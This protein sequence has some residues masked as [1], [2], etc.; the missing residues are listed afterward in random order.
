ML[1]LRRFYPFALRCCQCRTVSSDPLLSQ[2]SNCTHE[3]EVFDLVGKNKT[4][5]SE[6]H[7]GSAIDI[8]WQFQEKK[9][10][11]PRNSDYVKNHSHFIM[12]NNLAENK[13]SYMDNEALIHMLYNILRSAVLGVE[14]HDSLVREL[15]VE[16]WR[17]LDGLSLAALSKFALCLHKQKLVKSPLMGQ[18]A[19]IVNKNLDSMQDTRVLPVLM[20]SISSVISKNL[21]NRLMQK[22]EGALENI[23]LVSSDHAMHFVQFLRNIKLQHHPL[24]DKCNR[25]FLRDAKQLDV[26]ELSTILQLYHSL[27]F[28]N[29]AFRLVAKQRLMA[30]MDECNNPLSFTQLFAALAPMAG[31]AVREQL[32]ETALLIADEFDHLQTLAVVEALKEMKYRNSQLI[33]KITD[34]LHKHLDMYRST[35]LARL[36][37][38]IVFLQVHDPDFYSKLQKWLIRRLQESVT[39]TDI[40]IL[41]HLVSIL[42][43]SHMDEAIAARIDGI[44][45][46]CN[47][48]YLNFFATA[49]TKWVRHNQSNQRRG[50][51]LHG[52][53]LQ[54]IK[55]HAFQRLQQANDLDHLLEELKFLAG[56]WFEEILLEQTMV[57]LQRL[58]DQIAWKNM[59]LYSSFIV[60]TNYLCPLL[61]DKMAAV[62]MEHVD[63]I[64]KSEAYLLLLPFARLHYIDPPHVQEFFEACIG[65]SS[66]HISRFEPHLLVLL[67]YICALIEHFPADLIKA[68]FNI[69]FLAKLDTQLEIFTSALCRKVHTRLMELNRA[70]CLE[71]PDLQIPWFHEQ[72]CQQLM[73]LHQQ[74]HR[75][76]GE[77]LGGSHFVRVSVFTSYYHEIDFECV[78]DRNKKPLPYVDENGA[79]ADLKNVHWSQESPLL[80]RKELPPG[81]QRIAVEFLDSSAFCSNSNTPT[82]ETAIKK[83][84]LEIL[85]YHV[86]QIPHFEWNSMELSS[87][88]AW[89]EY[90]KKK[91]FERA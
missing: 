75:L 33:K 19:E 69:K 73:A 52:I 80:E 4:K 77:I 27:R 47:L 32:I 49:I 28:N 78:L 20:S 54:K 61:L 67:G 16:G 13:I 51:G 53:L 6:K 22:A 56:E 10:N 41:T 85:G 7:V 55:Y 36:L 42:P 74:I 81:A 39:L 1:C 24:L 50:S 70:V 25:V 35:E 8:L 90:L 86:V 83:R 71:C 9:H 17:R 31:P 68:I 79:R 37:R 2:L 11:F 76:L 30:I 45:P 29:S 58:V 43:S 34:V 72:Y 26:E 14:A 48:N 57:T 23:E 63:K 88:D 5:L 46:Q 65:Q 15:V 82:G 62:A 91:I 40:C 66:K 87:K 64:Y 59:L 38:S 12:L 84:H 60:K 3:D 18:I 44:L 89:I 21:Q